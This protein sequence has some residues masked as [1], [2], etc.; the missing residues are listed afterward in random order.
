MEGWTRSFCFSEDGGV[1]DMREVGR[2][3]DTGFDVLFGDA[4][5]QQGA[6]P[7]GEASSST[8]VLQ[9]QAPSGPQDCPTLSELPLAAVINSRTVSFSIVLSSPSG[10]GRPLY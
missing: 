2:L 4:Q 7:S 9:Q 8:S 5:Q 10:A 6:M 1:E 3:A